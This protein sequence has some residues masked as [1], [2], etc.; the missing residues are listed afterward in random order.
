MTF[1][2][3]VL[4]LMVALCFLLV[5]VAS[6]QNWQLLSADAFQRRPTVALTS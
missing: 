3:D 4:S 6:S 2:L 5:G 1:L